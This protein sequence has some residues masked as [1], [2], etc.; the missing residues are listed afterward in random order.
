[1]TVL[2]QGVHRMSLV[3]KAKKQKTGGPGS[4]LYL[5]ISVCHTG[6]ENKTTYVSG[7]C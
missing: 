3:E 6:P 5:T 4:R 2:L 7:L 1:M